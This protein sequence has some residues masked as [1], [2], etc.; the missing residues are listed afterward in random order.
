[1]P[2]IIVRIEWDWPDEQHWLNPDS[3]ALALHAYCENTRF[4]VTELELAKGKMAEAE[5]AELDITPE[6]GGI[7]TAFMLL[8]PTVWT[9]GLLALAVCAGV[10]LMCGLVLA[11]VDLMGPQRR[12]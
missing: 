8:L 4:S 9:R 1:M 11:L 12:G 10:A 5:L 3:V 6:R 7:V 2:G